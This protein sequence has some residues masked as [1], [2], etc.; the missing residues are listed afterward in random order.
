MMER[1]DVARLADESLERFEPSPAEAYRFGVLTTSGTSGKGALVRLIELERQRGSAYVEEWQNKDERIVVVYGS[2]CTR[3]LQML[4]LRKADA[5]ARGIALDANDL[6]PELEGLLGDI[7]PT[8]VVGAPSFML[9]V[10]ECAG[11]SVREGIASLRCAGER[12]SGAQHTLLRGAYPNASIDVTYTS[13][14]T[15]TISKPLCGH[16]LL[17]HYHLREGVSVRIAN[18]DE[19]GVGDILVD[20]SG[21]RIVP[22]RQYRIGDIGRLRDEPCACGESET[23]EVLGRKG[24]DYIKLAGAILRA[25]EFDRVAQKLALF[26]DYRAE[27]SDSVEGGKYKGTIC[28]KIYNPHTQSQDI[29]RQF[30]EELFI[31]PTKTLAGLI[32]EGVFAS[33]EIIVAKEPFS[34]TSKEIRLRQKA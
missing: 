5:T 13:I 4:A 26:D 29:A 19:D 1:E 25:E 16:L 31:T 23:L 6:C 21:D 2:R 14:E 9:R 10:A 32:G 27:V 8:R 22:I 18:A 33:L 3:L 17:S 24:I 7:A 28:L 12:L 30:A 34:T 11:A 15:G 20:V